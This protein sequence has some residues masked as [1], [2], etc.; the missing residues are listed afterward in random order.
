MTYSMAVVIKT[1][2]PARALV[3]E[4]DLKIRLKLFDYFPMLV[5]II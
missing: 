2:I 5:Q 1:G 4:K 3:T